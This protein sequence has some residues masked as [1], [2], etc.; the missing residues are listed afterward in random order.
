MRL[1]E[2]ST[3]IRSSAAGSRGNAPARFQGKPAWEQGAAFA[4]R[5]S[6]R[7]RPGGP[8]QPGSRRR[9]ADNLEAD[10]GRDPRRVRYGLLVREALAALGASK[11]HQAPRRR[12]WRSAARSVRRSPPAAAPAAHGEGGAFRNSPTGVKIAFVR[13]EGEELHYALRIR[14]NQFLQGNT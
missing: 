8:L 3:P 2:A 1:P 10:G 5:P 14:N 7:S 13:A 9:G 6:R 4:P 11:A 12:R